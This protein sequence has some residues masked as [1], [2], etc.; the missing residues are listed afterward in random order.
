MVSKSDIEMLEDITKETK[1]LS[2]GAEN[3]EVDTKDDYDFTLKQLGKCYEAMEFV[4]KMLRPQIDELYKKH[5][6]KTGQ[7]NGLITPIKAAI[8][9]FKGKVAEYLLKAKQGIEAEALEAKKR[10]EAAG[11]DTGLI[12]VNTGM[13][14]VKD[15]AKEGGMALVEE[16][17]YEVVNPDLV[18]RE[19]LMLDTKRIGARVRSMKGEANIPGVKV[20]KTATLRRIAA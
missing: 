2:D 9:I 17:S 16:W 7:Y 19:Y 12:T 8:A 1:E 15:L 6:E 10:L 14:V 20:T 18:P 4:E 3:L 5:K 13:S 11:M